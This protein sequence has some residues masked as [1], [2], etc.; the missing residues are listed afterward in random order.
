L[1]LTPD[2]LEIIDGPDDNGAELYLEAEEEAA[3]QKME[4][5]LFKDKEDDAELHR[6]TAFEDLSYEVQQAEIQHLKNAEHL[7]EAY[8]QDGV[9]LVDG[10]NEVREKLE[11]E[12]L[13]EEYED[14]EGR[15]PWTR[16]TRSAWTSPRMKP[17]RPK[18]TTSS[19]QTSKVDTD[20][21]REP[22]HTLRR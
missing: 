5:A 21:E 7:L 13:V 19:T 20:E 22:P 8:G 15:T 6:T 4:K 16:T 14:E 9:E 17:R 1:R 10:I 11:L 3:Q 12:Q 18:P 2:E